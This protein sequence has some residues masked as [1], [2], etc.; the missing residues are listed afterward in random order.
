MDLRVFAEYHVGVEDAVGVEQALEL[1]H[2]LVSIAAPFQ[3][4][5]RG[6][7]A[8]GAVFSLQRATELH[9]HQL[10]DVVHERLIACDF[11]AA[12][13]ALGEHEVQIA[14]QGMSE[15]DG[16]VVVM[17]VEQGDQAV[18]ANRQLFN[19]EGHVFDDHGGAGFAHGA[20]GREGVFADGPQAGVFQ[21]VFGE[22]DL[23]LHGECRQGGHDS[24]QL[25]VQQRW[26]SG[27]GFDQ[28]CAGVFR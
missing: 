5:E 24:R 8:A 16:F 15:K 2:Q 9:S 17:F 25:F 10:R 7:I 27:A 22:V 11:F 26:R 6:H 23:L 20:Y 21:W 18:H 28:Q 3:F 4:D 12:V 19:R 13:E 14:F 1:P